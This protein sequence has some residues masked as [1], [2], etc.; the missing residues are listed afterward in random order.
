M[1]CLSWKFEVRDRSSEMEE[2]EREREKFRKRV[3]FSHPHSELDMPQNV[4][5]VA[6][7][8]ICAFSARI[9]SETSESDPL[10]GFSFVFASYHPSSL[11]ND[12]GSLPPPL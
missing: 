5:E 10:M 12:P 1:T 6:H 8:K 2:R 9:S 11:S 4:S 3:R 7:C